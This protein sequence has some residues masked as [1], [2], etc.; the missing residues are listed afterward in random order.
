ML[1]YSRSMPR[2]I[3][4][5]EISSG[6]MMDASTSETNSD[7]VCNAFDR[8]EHQRV[9]HAKH[10]RICSC[11]LPSPCHHSRSARRDRVLAEELERQLPREV[12]HVERRRLVHI[13]TAARLEARRDLLCKLHPVLVRRNHAHAQARRQLDERIELRVALF[14]TGAATTAADSIVLSGRRR[15]GFDGPCLMSP[16]SRG[17]HA[18]GARIPVRGVP[19]QHANIDRVEKVYCDQWARG[20]S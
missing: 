10:A 17:G 5:Q 6:G 9:H 19:F 3:S 18:D 11:I 1:M 20:R 16:L 7:G 2:A 12:R 15:R 4:T 13:R 14:C 8:P